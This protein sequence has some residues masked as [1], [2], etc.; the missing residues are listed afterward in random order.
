MSTNVKGLERALLLLFIASGFAG[1]IYQAI[2]SHYLGLTLGHAAYAQTLVLA[3]FMGGMALGAWLV[4]RTG[5]RWTRLIFAY[6]IV[7]ILVGLAG[8]AF[9]PAFLAYTDFSQSVVYPALESGGA[10]RAWQWGTAALLIAPQSILL[11]MTFPLMSGGFLRVAPKEDGEILGGLYFT[12][13]I[14]AAF[15][16][17]FATFVLLPRVGMPGAVFTAGVINLAVGVLAWRV[18]RRADVLE[19]RPIVAVPP[20]SAEGGDQR[21]RKMMLTAALVTGASSFVYEISWV[22]MLNQVLGTTLHSFELM[23]SAFILGLAF[24][25]LWVRRRSARIADPVRYVGYA[26]V[27]MGIAAL[28]SI[29]VFSESF[30]WVG[31][32]VES[33]PKTEAGYSWFMLASGAISLGVMFPAAFFAGMTLPLLTMALLRNRAGEESIG[34]IYAANTLGAILGVAIAIHILIPLV[35]L[36]LALVTAAAVDILLGVVL[37][38]LYTTQGWSKQAWFATVAGLLVTIS[39]L[40]MGQIDPRRL[41]SGVF[42]HGNAQLD[43]DVEVHYMRDGKTASVSFITRDTVGVIAT[44]GKPDASIQLLRDG[45]PTGDEITMAMLGVLPLAVH[46][47]PDEVAVIGWGSGMTTHLLLGSE[48]V[49]SVET[50]EIER[51]MYDGARHFGSRVARAYLDPRSSVQFDDARTYFSSGR[52]S[53]DVIISEP[54]NPWVSGVASL[55][56][57]E[58]YGFLRQ[59]LKPGGVV[60][61]WVQGYELDDPLLATMVAALL[62]NF[63][64]VDAYST[65]GSDLIFVLSDTPVSAPSMRSFSS[66]DLAAELA[67]VGLT[68]DGDFIVRRIGDRTMLDAYARLYN[69]P[70]HTDFLP[71][72][73]L[74]A[75]RARFVGSS[76]QG[77]DNLVR[78]GMPVLEVTA[79][80]IPVSL[81]EGVTRANDQSGAND[82]LKARLVHELLSGGSSTELKS[83]ES[84]LYDYVAELKALSGSRVSG[85]DLDKWLQAASV[86]ADFSI[87]YLPAED[88]GPMWLSPEWIRQEDQGPEVA[89]VL[90]AFRAA[91]LRDGSA[92]RRDGLAAL[93]L[94]GQGRPAA[95]REQLLTIAVLGA[96]LEGDIEGGE[97]IER[98]HGRGVAAGGTYGFVR[99]YLLAWIDTKRAQSEQ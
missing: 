3:I 28:L 4:S 27:F 22:R 23:L 75:P 29:F 76:A 39:I 44:N 54:S 24:G 14:G 96:I 5:V 36:R 37:L 72:V 81:A 89:A 77:I 70:A 95:L 12:N 61:Q 53:Y 91:A 74:N 59:H 69:A 25:G 33:L 21:L 88:Q 97:Q 65:N 93:E 50:V 30:R 46:P 9:H 35:G 85:Q 83:V 31:F 20:A 82:H 58:F 41:A 15:G 13:S 8:I 80:R 90:A 56:T 19:S 6:A 11:G 57:S 43:D 68:G 40:S 38:R 45:V 79:G 10:V 2:W 16:A 51:A 49:K 67:R 99:G 55:F 47:S 71:L 7:E 32:L 64:Y 94:I 48:A 87:S 73:S 60:V 66:G 63:E 78:A 92:M 86:V 26:Q 17:L 52:R 34:R 42:R 18:S 1:L 84:V 62:E 98:T